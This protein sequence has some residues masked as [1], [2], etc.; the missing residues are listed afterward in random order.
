MKMLPHYNCLNIVL[1]SL[2]LIFSRG[3]TQSVPNAALRSAPDRN[4]LVSPQITSVRV[5]AQNWSDEMARKYYNTPQ[6]SRLLRYQWFLNLEQADSDRPFRD[7]ENI[8]SLGYL[9]R[10]SGP[11]NPDGLPVGFVK[12]EGY[13][14]MTC[15]ACHTAQV[16]YQNTAWLIDGGPTLGDGEMLLRKLES[17][18]KATFYDPAKF[19]HF[20]RAVLGRKDAPAAR[21]GLKKDLQAAIDKRSGYNARNLPRSNEPRFGPGRIDAFA[22]ILNEVAVTFA[23]MP[24]N[25]TKAD[26]PVSYP[27]LWDTPQ[28]DKVQWNGIAEN[29]EKEIGDLIL[30]TNQIGALGRNVGEVVGVFADV[31]TNKDPGWVGGYASSVNRENLI[32]L[33]NLVGELWSPLWPEEFG[34]PNPDLVAQGKKLYMQSCVSCHTLITRND[35]SRK[36]TAIMRDVGTDQTM[37]KNVATR[38][39][40]TGVFKGRRFLLWPFKA[41]GAEEPLAD[42]LSHIG[43]RV[44]VGSHLIDPDSQIPFRYAVNAIIRTNGAE[45]AGTFAELRF[46]PNGKLAQAVALS[47][48]IAAR[49]L[50]EPF[51]ATG[52]IMATQDLERV[53]PRLQQLSKR[54]TISGEIATLDLSHLPPASVQVV[55]PYKARPLNGIWATAPYLHNGSVSN[56]DDLLKPAA[57]RTKRFRL[58]SREFDPQ[59]VGFRTDQGEYE[60]DTAASPGNSNA[61]HDFASGTYDRIFTNADREQLLAYL[62]TL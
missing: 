35:E 36:V 56:L 39:G 58:G 50:D 32:Q 7:E 60:F 33:E 34:K 45:V 49:Q 54:M 5:L 52:E 53:S 28:H 61:G 11:G 51:T 8:R 10:S 17:A 27:C 22:G 37:A 42:L 2:V 38:M 24:T 4:L 16:N 43:Q 46:A 62:K 15:A 1:V 25:Q 19:D 29:T 3:Y 14:G 20:A 41:I 6:G 12:D 44:I 30:G 48:S 21:S 47:Q 18:L 40:K 9:P 55:F 26:A 57:E 23:H 31:D 59:K 13:V